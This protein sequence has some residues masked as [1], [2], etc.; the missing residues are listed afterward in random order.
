MAKSWMRVEKPLCNSLHAAPAVVPDPVAIGMTGAIVK[1]CGGFR[2]RL[3][4]NGMVRRLKPG[5]YKR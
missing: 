2:H 5:G 1:P 4:T 3:E